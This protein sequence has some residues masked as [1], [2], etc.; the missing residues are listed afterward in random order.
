MPATKQVAA[1]TATTTEEIKLEPSVRRKLLI[2]L[3]TYES[4]HTQKKALELAM[5]KIK[6]KVSAIRNETGAQ[7]LE[8]EGFRVTLVAPTRKKFNAK[9]FVKLG[10]DIDIYNQANEETL[11]T[12]YE[13]ISL[14]GTKE[15]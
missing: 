8:L 6:S 13:K 2:E 5:D 11:V 4:L 3:R 14:P 12:P 9:A 10:G 1:V 7:S 15:E